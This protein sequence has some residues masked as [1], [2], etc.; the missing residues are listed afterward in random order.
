MSPRASFLPPALS[1]LALARLV[2]VSQPPFHPAL[3]SVLCS[4]PVPGEVRPPT[5]VRVLRMEEVCDGSDRH[6]TTLLVSFP[7]HAFTSRHVHENALIAYAL[8]SRVRSQ[9]D[10][11]SVAELRQGDTFHEAVGTIHSF[12]ENPGDKPASMLATIVHPPGA[13]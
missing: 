6:T 13:A 1:L 8:S 7:P 3:L 2:P 10:D 12:I 4:A 5:T 9:L 11:G